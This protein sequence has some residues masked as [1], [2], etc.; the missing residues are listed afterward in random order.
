MLRLNSETQEKII[1]DLG[2]KTEFCSVFYMA[3]ILFS[4]R[5][6]KATDCAVAPMLATHLHKCWLLMTLA[7][8]IQHLDASTGL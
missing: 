2:K 7:V 4:L 8:Y 5:L 1:R 6:T 3:V